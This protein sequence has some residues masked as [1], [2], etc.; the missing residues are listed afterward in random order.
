[1]NTD[2]HNLIPVKDLTVAVDWLTVTTSEAE[3]SAT[4]IHNLFSTVGVSQIIQGISRPWHFCGYH[5]KAFDG[6][7]YGLR[8]DDEAIV[9]LSGKA[10]ATYWSKVAPTR[11]KCTRIDLA[12][13]CALEQ[14]DYNVGQRAYLDASSAFAG[15]S[16]VVYNS[17]GGSTCYIGSR[18][19]QKFARLY[20]KGAEEGMQPGELWRYEIEL[21]KPLSEVAVDHLLRAKDPA[22]WI[23]QYVWMIFTGR[24]IKPLF[25]STNAQCAIEVEAS[26]TSV[27]QKLQWL[28]SQVAPTVGRLIVEGYEVEVL[29]ALRIPARPFISAPAKEAGK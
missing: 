3:K 6:L 27:A 1:M 25:T 2:A 7:R 5:G 11:G 9:I 15:K 29:D 18:T 16:S 14:A 28:S 24:G 21:K 12:V 17:R 22:G 20:D 19:S 23:A 8:G 4:L 10:A 26:I 13:T